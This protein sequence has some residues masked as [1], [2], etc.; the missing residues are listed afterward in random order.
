MEFAVDLADEWRGPAQL[1]EAAE[2]VEQ[3]AAAFATLKADERRALT[4]IAAGYSYAE[5]GRI[6]S[7]TLTKINRCAAEGRGRLRDFLAEGGEN[8]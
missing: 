5:I 6:C 2:E 1:A 8:P 4:L 7:W 3:F